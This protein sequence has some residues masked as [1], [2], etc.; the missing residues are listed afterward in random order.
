MACILS[1]ETSSKICSVAIH[2]KDGILV[3]AEVHI[4]Q[5]HASKLSPLIEQCISVSGITWKEVEAVAVSSGP[6]SYTGL[7]IGVSTAKGLCYALGIPLI[8]IGT[9][10]LLAFQMSKQANRSTMLCP[11]IDARR[12][13][14]YC[15]VVDNNL[16]EVTKVESKVITEDSFS[17]I[18]MNNK[19]GFFGDGAPKC[20]EV[21]KSP[22][23]YFVDDVYPSAS[24][25]G[26]I[27]HEKFSK[28]Q[29]EDL[30]NFEPFYL[31]EF[32]IKTSAK[33]IL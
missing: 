28:G 12:M 15:M 29:T 14:V 31:K 8:A 3:S 7:R 1:L 17:E 24:Q 27:A 11:M 33:Q 26:F 22:N 19:I 9:L 18:L 6:G 13:E 32:V 30:V 20:R 25:L 10:E 23:A 16:K 21:I 2:N 5:S 4:K